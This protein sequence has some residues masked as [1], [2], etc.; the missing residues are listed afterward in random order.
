MLLFLPWGLRDELVRRE[1]GISF[2]LRINRS[3]NKPGEF[4]TMLL[5]HIWKNMVD[6][7]NIV[8]DDE[9]SD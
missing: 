6:C 4:K 1:E 5:E 7:D 2:Q 9:M 3:N 8:S